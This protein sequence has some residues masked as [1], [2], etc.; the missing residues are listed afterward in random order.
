MK[1]SGSLARSLLSARGMRTRTAGL[2]AVFCL[3]FTP[4]AAS[5]ATGADDGVLAGYRK[6]YATDDEGARRDFER[7]LASSPRHLGARFG[8]LHVMDRQLRDDRAGMAAF[9]QALDALIADAEARYRRAASDSEALFYAANGYL[10][11]ARHRVAY[12]KGMW[13]AARDG[14]RA[15]RLIETY[16]AR[17]PEH[18]DAYFALGT[19]N[20]YVELAPTF[21]KVL[22]TILFLPSGNRVEGLK[23]LERAHREGAI[24][25]PLAGMLL[26]EIN[27]QFE[28]RPAE[29]IR[30][31]ERLAREYPENPSV[32]FALAELYLSPAVEEPA[33][34]VEQYEAVIAREDRR[35]GPPRAARFRARLGLASA[36]VTLWQIPA[37]IDGLSRTIAAAPEAPPWVMP[38]F[39]LRRGNYRALLGDAQ[40]AEDARRVLAEPAW[41]DWH[42]QATDQMAWMESRR[43]SGEA[44]VYAALVPGNRLAAERRWHEARAAFDAVKAQHPDDPQVRFRTAQLRFRQWDLRGLDQEFAALARV[45]RHPD[46]LKAQ[47]LLYLGRV[48]DLAGRRAEAV[49]AYQQIVDGYERQSAAWPAKVGLVTPYQ[50]R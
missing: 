48:H 23:Q 43:A 15:K 46:W 4:L 11:R 40:A 12:G 25:A 16:V 18:G 42:K 3:F 31:G 9:E 45:R 37:A 13:G 17:H 24:F 19:Y 7:I 8:M 28:A 20:Y 47:A 50:R 26:I 33:R 35:A 2:A 49:K 1:T 44:A 21:A 36:R 22:R 6:F 34:A 30:I 41:K 27:S 32:Q 10:V 5:A 38:T 14:A 39:L 29:G